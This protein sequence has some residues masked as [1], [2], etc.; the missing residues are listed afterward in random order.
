[1]ERPEF[2]L[3]TWLF[4]YCCNLYQRQNLMLCQ[5]GAVHDH[6][7]READGDAAGGVTKLYPIQM[8][9]LLRFIFAPCT[10]TD[11][12]CSAA[13]STDWVEWSFSSSDSDFKFRLG[14][15][16]VSGLETVLNPATHMNTSLFLSLVLT[17]LPI[18]SALTPQWRGLINGTVIYLG[19]GL[20][21]LCFFVC[22]S[23]TNRP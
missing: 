10:I 11:S 20:V 13:W 17:F 22:I 9:G 23:K 4:L 1:M 15:P 7:G 3:A 18:V 12:E 16:E 6:C 8:M 14:G 19:L 21:A 2:R 5:P